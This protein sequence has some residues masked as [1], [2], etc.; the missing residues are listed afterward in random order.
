M[1][2]N[3]FTK[4]GELLAILI[5]SNY[6][7]DGLNFV[8]PDEFPF[9]LG[10]HNHKKGF[11]SEPHE[12]PP[13]LNVDKLESQEFFLVRK[14]KV[15]VELYHK[16]ELIDS[17]ILEQGDMILLNCGHSVEFLENSEMME[18]KQGPYR[19]KSEDKIFLK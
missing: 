8:T 19:G 4:D 18:L 10:M 5:K 16:K 13:L 9:Q 15:K 12:H 3:K 14:G 7:E 1:S 2:I 17:C 6:S 11:I